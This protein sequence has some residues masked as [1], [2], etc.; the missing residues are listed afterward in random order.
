MEKKE[1]ESTNT[2]N[3]TKESIY[4]NVLEDLN[5]EQLS[6]IKRAIKARD[7]EALIKLFKDSFEGLKVFNSAEF[8]AN[9]GLKPNKTFL[10]EF[11]TLLFLAFKRALT[12]EPTPL[13]VL[14]NLLTRKPV[15]Y[16]REVKKINKLTNSNREINKLT[17][18]KLTN[19]KFSLLY[20]VLLHRHFDSFEYHSLFMTLSRLFDDLEKKRLVRMCDS[21]YK[22][23]E[24]TAKGLIFCLNKLQPKLPNLESTIK[25]TE[26][27]NKILEAF[28]A[29]IG[30]DPEKEQ[31]YKNGKNITL[32]LSDLLTFDYGLYEYIINNPDDFFNL[33]ENRVHLI[34]PPDVLLED[35]VNFGAESIDKIM[36]FE[37][38]ITMFKEPMIFIKSATFQCAKCGEEKPVEFQ[39]YKKPKVECDSCHS[40]KG[41]YINQKL[42]NLQE[43]VCK[44]HFDAMAIKCRTFWNS[45]TEQLRKI[46]Y[47]YVQ[48]RLRLLG[49]LRTDTF[50][51]QDRNANSL[52]FQLLS[53]QLAQEEEEKPLTKEAVKQQIKD[54]KGGYYDSL[55]ESFCPNVIGCENAKLGLLATLVMKG[56]KDRE[57]RLNLLLF[58]NSGIGKSLLLKSAKKLYNELEFQP[59]AQTT[60]R[61]LTAAIKQVNGERTVEPG[62]LVLQHSSAL[63]VE[64]INAITQEDQRA[65]LDSLE[66]GEVKISKAGYKISFPARTSIIGTCNPYN[67]WQVDLDLPPAEQTGLISA[68]LSRFDL[69]IYVEPLNEE[70]ESKVYEAFINRKKNKNKS[71]EFSR[72]FIKSLLVYAR[73]Y[74]VSADK[75]TEQQIKLNVMQLK[76]EFR[77]DDLRMFRGFRNLVEARA[78][79][80][81]SENIQPSHILWAYDFYSLMLKRW[82]GNF[83]NNSNR[84]NEIKQRMFDFLD[85]KKDKI[86][87]EDVKQALNITDKEEALFQ[88]IFKDLKY[89]GD[90]YEPKFGYVKAL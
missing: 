23:Y 48:K 65:L 90:I 46:P 33:V 2:H 28:Q 42:V 11:D 86:S 69:K 41:K 5:N 74:E 30:L 37:T 36:S 19:N 45:E 71:V 31:Q 66:N 35:S 55:I 84:A 17:I 22:S 89:K 62:L 10:R 78:R 13:K 25:Q 20:S 38:N 60:E 58:G 47:E 82:Y 76:K 7:E 26:K 3:E 49:I 21:K 75:E 59:A 24:I 53:Y 87:L 80:S 29:Y 18:N 51:R 6:T 83:S 67:G 72:D 56:D 39:N 8:L 32:D 63:G 12:A 15:I 85:Q 14:V 40:K 57:D 54:F 43:F 61:G 1:K 64:E 4:I 68:L 9:N 34:N 79:L 27:S 44:S 50:K 88:T 52:V 70:N 73:E 81:L 77:S 16:E